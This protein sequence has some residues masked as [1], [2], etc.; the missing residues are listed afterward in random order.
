M[1]DYQPYKRIFN[2]CRR[3]QTLSDEIK[4]YQLFVEFI[5]GYVDKHHFEKALTLSG[6]KQTG[7]Y[8]G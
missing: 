5:R 8:Y 1:K 6:L 3:T 2:P 4:K 7:K